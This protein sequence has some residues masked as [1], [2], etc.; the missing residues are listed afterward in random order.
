MEPWSTRLNRRERWQKTVETWRRGTGKSALCPRVHYA[1]VFAAQL[2]ADRERIPWATDVFGAE[3]GFRCFSVADPG[4]LQSTLSY[5]LLFFSPDPV[6]SEPVWDSWKEGF[7]AYLDAL[8]GDSFTHKKKFAILRHCLGPEGRNILKCIPKVCVP[9]AEAEGDGGI[10]EYVSA[11]KS[12]DVRFKA[13]KNVIMERH[14]FYKRVQVSGEPVASFVGALRMLTVTCD[15]KACEDEIIR[16]QL[17]EKTNNKKVQETLL[18]TP[19]LTLEKAVKIA[20][21]IESTTMFIEQ[22]NTPSDKDSHHLCLFS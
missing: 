16:D 12:P 18:S 8:D 7:E 21:R 3:R 13:C 1:G 14:T 6:S 9:L 4:G 10:D 17:V 2:Q 15:Y 5:I 22:I 19:K 20:T 11:I